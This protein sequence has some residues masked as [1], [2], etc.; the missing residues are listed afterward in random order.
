MSLSAAEPF[1][2]NDP[3]FNV[4]FDP[5]FAFGSE[6]ANLEYSIL[7]A[8]LGNPSPPDSASGTAPSPSQPQLQPTVPNSAWS[9]EPLHAQPHYQTGPQPS[10]P[11]TESAGLSIPEPTLAATAQP[12]PTAGFISYSPTQF[13]RPS[14]DSAT[15]YII[16][17]FL[18][19]GPAYAPVR[20]SALSPRRQWYSAYGRRSRILERGWSSFLR[21]FRTPLA[22]IIDFNAPEQ[23]R[24]PFRSSFLSI[25]DRVS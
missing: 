22:L 14:Q 25:P 3:L 19:P 20:A 23:P 11:F 5:H 2:T 9:P 7:S 10:Y 4:S 24:Q 15:E 21:A 12:S 16:S 17:S 8:I 18:P 6:A 1:P 13:S